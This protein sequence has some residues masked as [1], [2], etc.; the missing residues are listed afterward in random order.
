MQG[1]SITGETLHVPVVTFARGFASGPAG[2]VK[3]GWPRSSTCWLTRSFEAY[4]VTDGFRQPLYHLHKFGQ[5]RFDARKT[6]I[7]LRKATVDPPVNFRDA[8]VRFGYPGDECR[9]GLNQGCYVL[10]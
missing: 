10:L 1:F 9:L 8:G 5:N 6:A 2:E 7:D 3:P 4:L